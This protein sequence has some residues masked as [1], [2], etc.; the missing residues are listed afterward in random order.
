MIAVQG[1]VQYVSDEEI[2]GWEGIHNTPQ[3][4]RDAT[5]ALLSGARTKSASIEDVNDIDHHLQVAPG[6][7]AYFANL[8]ERSGYLTVWVAECDKNRWQYD[9]QAMIDAPGPDAAKRQYCENL[10]GDDE[11]GLVRFEVNRAGY[12]LL[13]EEFPLETFR[14]LKTLYEKLVELHLN[15]RQTAAQWL[16][17]QGSAV[18]PARSPAVLLAPHT[19]EWFAALAAWNPQQAAHTRSIL[20]QSGSDAVCS[21][22]GDAPVRDYRLVGPG[23]P[24]GAICTLRLCNDC[25]RIRANMHAESLALLT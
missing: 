25:W 3:S 4:M 20:Q 8:Y 1:A 5:N 22:C 10:L 11:E 14:R 23:V 15:R 9:L 17:R 7:D 12:S 18:L 6:D 21:I 24:D 16:S 2:K 19:A 13:V